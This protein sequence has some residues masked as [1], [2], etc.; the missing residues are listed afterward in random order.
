MKSESSV[1]RKKLIGYGISAVLGTALLFLVLYLGN[2]WNLESEQEKLRVLT[3]AFTIPGI[4]LALGCALIFISNQ[5]G[6]NGVLYGLRRTKEVLLPFLP[7][8]YLRYRDYVDRRKEKRVKGYGFVLH[9]GLAFL[10][11]GIVL[12]I[13]FNV[14]YPN[15]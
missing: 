11:V 9:V 15:A 12:L 14:R 3:D 4:L 5:G 13:L 8:E 6:F 1:L 7:H 10:A 2:Y